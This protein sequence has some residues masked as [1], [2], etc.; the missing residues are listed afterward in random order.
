MC[1]CVCVCVGGRVFVWCMAHFVE[2]FSNYFK[3]ANSILII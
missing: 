2:S 3:N 1:V